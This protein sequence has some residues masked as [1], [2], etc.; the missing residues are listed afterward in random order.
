MPFRSTIW[1][2][3]EGFP[4]HDRNRTG[5]SNRRACRQTKRRRGQAPNGRI[6]D[7]DPVE[8]VV[9][10]PIGIDAIERAG[11][12]REAVVHRTRPEAAF[13]VAFAFVE[14]VG[15]N[16][17]LGLG[18]SIR[19]RRCRDRRTPSRRRR[20]R[21]VRQ[22]PSERSRRSARALPGASLRRRQSLQQLAFDVD[23]VERLLA[24]VPNR[25]FAELVLRTLTAQTLGGRLGPRG[26]TSRRF[27][28]IARSAAIVILPARRSRFALAGQLSIGRRVGGPRLGRTQREL[29]ESA[30]RTRGFCVDEYLRRSRLH[31]KSRP[32]AA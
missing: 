14:T 10:C 18:R 24:N 8:H 5:R 29:S 6:R 20:R 21:S 30:G 13:A 26:R 12:L 28:R 19:S 27:G 15:Q 9:H 11:V 31:K 25:N 17:R 4:S 16:M 23:P 3:F 32:K 7:P 22:T 1:R 2:R